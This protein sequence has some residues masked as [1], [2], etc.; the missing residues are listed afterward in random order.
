MREGGRERKVVGDYHRNKINN[1]NKYVGLVTTCKLCMMNETYGIEK[2][3]KEV[4]L[5]SQKN[6]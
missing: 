1:N 2:Y 6:I 3:K 5:K 4:L